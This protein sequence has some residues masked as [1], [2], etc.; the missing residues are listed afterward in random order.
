[1]LNTHLSSLRLKVLWLTASQPCS[2][3]EVE[4]CPAL[5]EWGGENR[6]A[7]TAPPFQVLMRAVPV[8]QFLPVYQPSPEE[9]KDPTLYANNVQRVMAQ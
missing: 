7:V 6:V 3:V 5:P 4:V 1:M 8:F 9:S 2:I